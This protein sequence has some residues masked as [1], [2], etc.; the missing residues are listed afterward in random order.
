MSSHVL[1]AACQ[2]NEYAQEAEDDEKTT[3]GFF[4]KALMDSLRSG[5]GSTFIDLIAG[6]PKWPDQMPFVAGDHKGGQIWYQE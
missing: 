6:L 4:T 1:L 2:K 3:H 5:Q